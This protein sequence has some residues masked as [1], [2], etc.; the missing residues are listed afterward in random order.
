MPETPHSGGVNPQVT[1]DVADLLDRIGTRLDAGFAEIKVLV[2]SKADKADLA[3]INARLD[4]HSKDISWLK[5][6]QRET[7]LVAE[8]LNV[9]NAKRGDWR[10]WALEAAI[11]AAACAGIL[12]G[13]LSGLHG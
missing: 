5:D 12:V 6:R 11:S 9:S 1:Y 10:R 8:T 7:V 4:E 13:V 2:A 3:G